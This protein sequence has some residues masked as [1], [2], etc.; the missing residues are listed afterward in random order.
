MK[1]IKLKVPYLSQL[2]N[3]YNPYGS[4]NTTSVATCFAYF[5]QPKISKDGVQLEDELTDYCYANHLDPQ[6]PFGLQELIKKHGYADDFQLDAK[7]A[8]VKSWLN[9]GNPCIVHGY[10]TKSGHIVTII[11]Y[12]DRGFIVHDPY[13]EWWQSGYDTKVSGAGLLYSYAMMREVC[14]GDGD[15]WIH[16]VSP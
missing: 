12:N 16:Y 11:G 13:G 15:L 6:S 14:G 5:G 10:F 2:D 7:W 3:L 9:G 1:E 8:D 4:C